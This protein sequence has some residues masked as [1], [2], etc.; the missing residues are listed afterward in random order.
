MSLTNL[1]ASSRL[2]HQTCLSEV[3]IHSSDKKSEQSPLALS[4]VCIHIS[5]MSIHEQIAERIEKGSTEMIWTATDFA[6]LGRR[7]AVDK[8]L[9]RLEDAGN[10]NRVERGFYHK[11]SVNP[12][13]QSERVPQYTAL[14]DALKRREGIK[15]LVDGMTAANDLGLTTTVPAKIIVHTDSRRKT[16]ALPGQLIEF[17]HTAPSRLTWADRPAMRLVQALT[18]LR[19]R[20]QEATKQ[21]LSRLDEIFR[22]EGAGA[23]T[24]DLKQDFSKLPGAWMQ[25]L[26]RSYVYA[27]EPEARATK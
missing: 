15:I 25:D 18:W 17:K 22:G 5:D 2:V 8:A 26:L 14:L 16:L 20:G 1:L 13:T 7:D 21:T 6:D 23:I 27:T 11:R 24:D 19:E 12:L 9:E 10:L 4:E 3:C